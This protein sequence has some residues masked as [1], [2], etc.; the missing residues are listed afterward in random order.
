MQKVNLPSL[1]RPKLLR[2]RVYDV[3]RDRIRDGAIPG[4]YRL[5]EEELAEQFGVS[6]T[7]V[8]AAIH[9]L[10]AEGWVVETDSRGYEVVSVTIE[11]IEDALE[12]RRLLERYAARRAARAITRG[13]LEELRSI[14]E[15][16]KACLERDDADAL[17]ELTI[18]NEHLH[19]SIA[20]A[21]GS[22]ML[23]NV[24]DYLRTRPVYNFY[25]LG[26]E[27]NV[28]RF[29]ESHCRLV[30]ALENGDAEMA[31]AEVDYHINLARE[32]LT[33]HK[34]RLS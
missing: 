17:A 32:I 19:G 7:P 9:R 12:I 1:G 33:V 3:L 24:L 27:E 6:R 10:Q 5:I 29:A 14:C 34:E 15:Q 23:S 28:H 18:L 2:D 25:A 26:A 4:G 8:R 11:D 31:E 30:Q 22:K 21:A 16:E 20:D 13:E